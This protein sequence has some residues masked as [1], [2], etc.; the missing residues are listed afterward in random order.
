MFGHPLFPPSQATSPEPERTWAAQGRKSPARA[1]RY[2]PA[3]GHL[4]WMKFFTYTPPWME[5]MGENEAGSAFPAALNG[6]L[7]GNG[8]WYDVPAQWRR[9]KNIND[10]AMG[11]GCSRDT[12]LTGSVR[13]VLYFIFWT[14]PH[15]IAGE[16]KGR[17]LAASPVPAAFLLSARRRCSGMNFLKKRG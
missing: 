13:N 17:M 4:K 16:R 14:R 5:Q 1:L 8:P 11:Q 10:S 7:H 6:P 9:G 12:E 2:C 15:F 3:D